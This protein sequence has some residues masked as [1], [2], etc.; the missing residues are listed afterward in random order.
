MAKITILL[1]EDHDV[2]REG[3]R[4]LLR[5]EQDMEVVGEARDG[6]QA[7]GLTRETSPDV[8]VMDISMP[9]LNGLEAT[10]QILQSVP[11][12]KVLVLSAYDDSDCVAQMIQAGA[13]GYLTKRSAGDHLSEAIRTVRCGRP[14]YSPEIAKRVR[15]RQAALLR[16]DRSSRNQFELTPREEEVLQLIADGLPNKGIASQLSIGTKTVEKHRQTLM[17][18]LNI[19][20]AAGLTRYAISTGMVPNS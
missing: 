12:T 14:F 8:V 20:E 17:N 9:L 13:T 16:T 11:R 2:V 1:A 19:H 7:V 6:L 10:R 15:E 4:A 18:K 3:L 5:A